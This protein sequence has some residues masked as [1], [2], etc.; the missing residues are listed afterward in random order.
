VNTE[1]ISNYSNPVGNLP[2]EA[3]LGALLWFTVP[4]DATVSLDQART[5]LEGLGAD[6]SALRAELRPI[7]AYQKAANELKRTFPAVDGV[8]STFMVRPVGHDADSAFRH[9][10]LERAQTKKGA[11][12]R[13]LYEK[14]AE[15][16]YHRGTKTGG[17]GGVYQGESVE[18][19]RTTNYLGVPLTDTEDDWLTSHLDNFE[20]RFRF[21]TANLDSHGIRT[22][23]RDSIWNM[24]GVSVR[25]AGGVY[26]VRREH[27]A[28][29]R[30]IGEWVKSLGCDFH[31]LPLLD[32]VEQR[33]M[34][35]EAFQDASVKEADAL[36]AEIARILEDKERKVSPATFD[37]YGEMASE[38]AERIQEYQLMLGGKA[39]RAKVQVQLFA[40]QVMT[41]STRVREPKSRR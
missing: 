23:V 40:Q 13:L 30:V 12:R 34:V 24:R 1:V 21:L 15:L 39:E 6:L 19:V 29:M 27:I 33:E 11:K 41:L 16:I 32:L 4:G 25:E 18:V 8:K 36:M 10:I 2:D 22:F 37:R 31:S 14:V 28:P 35:L 9:I 20:S 26:F 5:D 17:I 3:F 7:D 38:L